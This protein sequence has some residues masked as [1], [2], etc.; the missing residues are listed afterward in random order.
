MLTRF[1]TDC[2]RQFIYSHES[3]WL[4]EYG[5]LVADKE[6]S[7]HSARVLILSLKNS[8]WNKINV[9]NLGPELFAGSPRVAVCI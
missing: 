8:K 1:K 2:D 6:F 9:L 5:Y 4:D 3:G 7:A